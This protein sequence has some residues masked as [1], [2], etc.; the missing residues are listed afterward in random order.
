ML[1]TEGL[2]RLRLRQPCERPACAHEW[3][4]PYLLTA[5]V[6]AMAAV[7]LPPGVCSGGGST[8]ASCPGTVVIS[9]FHGGK[10][11]ACPTGSRCTG[12]LCSVGH[13]VNG[14]AYD[15]GVH[16]FDVS[17]NDCSCAEVAEAA[18]FDEVREK[19][20]LW[21]VGAHHKTGSFLMERI[22]GRL[23][24]E[25]SPPLKIIV[26]S[27]NPVTS[28]QWAKM[29]KAETDVVVTFHASGI[30]PSLVATMDARPYRFVHIVRDPADQVVS[31][32]LYE[33]QRLA[34]QGADRSH[35]AYLKVVRNAPDGTDESAL[36][37]MADFMTADLEEG[38]SQYEMAHADHNALNI[39]FEDFSVDFD[40]TVR[41][42]FSFLGVPAHQEDDFVRIAG[43]EDLKKKTSEWL[44]NSSHVTTGKN[45]VRRAEL[46]SVLLGSA[47]YSGMF[48]ALRRRLGYPE[49]AR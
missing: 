44:S 4:P 31:A 30:G 21:I 15:H 32:V 11:C 2:S 49:H 37:A 45:D 41:R 1:E 46:K 26:K 38:A 13:K 17:C 5:M 6:A 12:S 27:F 16:G 19:R 3:P 9:T 39:R 40:E 23:K 35:D 34:A 36:F 8:G 29:A 22:W 42:I 24:R 25:A 33:R 7:M 18:S 48:A 43:H 28:D 10:H 47:K 20:F 14:A